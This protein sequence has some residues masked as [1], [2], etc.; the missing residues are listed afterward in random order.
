MSLSKKPASGSVPPVE[1][2]SAE[3]PFQHLLLQ[4]SW[5]AAQGGDSSSLV[6]FFCA[7]TRM[8]LQVSGWLDDAGAGTRLLAA[9]ARLG[10]QFY[11]SCRQ[12]FRRSCGSAGPGT[13]H[14][15]GNCGAARSG[16]RAGARRPAQLKYSV[17]RARA[18]DC[19]CPLRLRE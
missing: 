7:E 12:D 2:K 18:T 8:F 3:D 4:L 16:G 9:L 11:G 19:R 5:A 6:E 17:D 10:P 13:R 1:S 14:T 15:A